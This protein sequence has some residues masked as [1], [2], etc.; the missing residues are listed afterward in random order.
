M[1]W[2]V[3]QQTLVWEKTPIQNTATLKESVVATCGELLQAVKTAISL[4]KTRKNN[5]NTAYA[6]FC[7]RAVVFYSTPPTPAIGGFENV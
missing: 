3:V 5:Q 7:V 4:T 2:Q 1:S 6:C